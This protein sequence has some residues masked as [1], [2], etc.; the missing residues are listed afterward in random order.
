MVQ[1][2]HRTRPGA[3]PPPK[4]RCGGFTLSKS[5]FFRVAT[6]IIAKNIS[7]LLPPR[8]ADLGGK[9]ACRL[10]KLFTLSKLSKARPQLRFA[11]LP[12]MRALMPVARFVSATQANERSPMN[13]RI[14]I[15]L[16]LTAL[17]CLAPGTCL[18]A[19][20]GADQKPAGAI[21]VLKKA[22]Q[23][24][25]EISPET[26][27]ALNGGQPAASPAGAQ[28]GKPAQQAKPGAGPKSTKAIYGDIIIHK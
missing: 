27:K 26:A 24:Q 21:E 10:S 8:N 5:P 4:D 3:A 9:P 20:P 18:A 28:S 22:I 14:S 17:L 2:N 1:A 7:V 11:L 25:G 16:L 12:A 19:E 6:G 13:R 23:A 15:P